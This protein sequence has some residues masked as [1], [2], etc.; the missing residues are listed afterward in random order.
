MSKASNAKAQFIKVRCKKCG[1]EHIM[2][3]RATIR[4]KCPGC[5]EVH[6]VPKG[7]KCRLVNC[8]VVEELK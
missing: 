5:G 4:V 3:S 6:S 1:A 2:F 7:G 8:R